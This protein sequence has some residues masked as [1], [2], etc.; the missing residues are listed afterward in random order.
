MQQAAGAKDRQMSLSELDLIMCFCMRSVAIVKITNSHTLR[1]CDILICA[2]HDQLL[3]EKQFCVYNHF[4][5][6]SVVTAA[7]NSICIHHLVS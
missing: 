4:L 5:M 3:K 6:N 1:Q 2:N 7:R